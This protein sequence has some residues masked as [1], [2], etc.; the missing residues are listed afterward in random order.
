MKLRTVS[1]AIYFGIC[2]QPL[3]QRFR[4]VRAV[5]AQDQLLR[6]QFGCAV[7]HDLFNG[8][9]QR[10]VDQNILNE[11]AIFISAIFAHNKLSVLVARKPGKCFSEFIRNADVF[12]VVS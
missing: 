12:M 3:I 4:I 6:P 8:S 2:S 10:I 11:Y 1:C 7:R 9:D 5:S